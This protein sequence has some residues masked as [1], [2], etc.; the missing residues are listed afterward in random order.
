MIGNVKHQLIAT[1]TTRTALAIAGLCLAAGVWART[2]T[3]SPTQ[4]P[5]QKG[6][7]MTAHARGTFEVKLTPQ[8]DAGTDP[9]LGR[10]TIDK[11]YQG[12]LEG[13]GKGQMLTAGPVAKGSGGYVAMELVDGKVAG[14]TGTFALQHSG[15]MTQG[16]PELSITVVPGSATGQLEGLAGKMN[17]IVEGG[18]HSY[19]FEYTVKRSQ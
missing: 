5:T 1:K 10:M 19:D 6:T 4:S 8:T 9:S 17:I 3:G 14:R 12:D 13:S 7:A 18:Q 11:Q 16:K 2:Q 15:T